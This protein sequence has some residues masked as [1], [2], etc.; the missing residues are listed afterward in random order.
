MTEIN[1]TQ[2]EEEKIQS[3]AKQDNFS[4]NDL[5]DL[6]LILRKRC[7]WDKEQTHQSVRMNFLEEAYETV[8]AIDSGDNENLCEELGD[9]LLQVVFHAQISKECGEFSMD[10]VING[11]CRKLVLR[12]PHIFGDIKVK[13]TDEVLDN[14]D[15]IKAVEKSQKNT[16]KKLDD[17]PKALPSLLRCQKLQSRAHK[18]GKFE[19]SDMYSELTKE[20]AEEMI[21]IQLFNICSA[22][23]LLDINA[24][25]A[26]N[27]KNND[28]IENF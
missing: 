8:D 5:L 3:F 18:D 17:V 27:R 22:A 1:Y 23:K 15:K 26:L 28:F 16:R 25:E 19:Y 9:V 13:N 21:G 14:W 2:Y 4:Y 12:H 24:E 20:Q 10:D 11:I 6:M 7:P